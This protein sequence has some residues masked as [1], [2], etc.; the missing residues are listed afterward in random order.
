MKRLFTYV[1]LLAVSIFIAK[2]QDTDFSM[3]KIKGIGLKVVQI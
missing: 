3:E 2:G 1:F